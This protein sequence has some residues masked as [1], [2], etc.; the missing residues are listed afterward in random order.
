MIEYFCKKHCQK[1]QDIRLLKNFIPIVL[2]T[3][4][5]TLDRK[6]GNQMKIIKFHLPLHFADDILRFGSMANYDSG[7]GE[8]HHKEFAK[9]TA[10]NTQRRKDVFELQT[11]SRQVENL[12]IN[13][14][15]DYMFYN[16]KNAPNANT[17][18]KKN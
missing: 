2:K 8:S 1:K 12:A 7:V 6:E 5:A 3:V 15:H 4:K 9:K 14:A 13:R 11:A 17:D 16:L 10:N 18:A